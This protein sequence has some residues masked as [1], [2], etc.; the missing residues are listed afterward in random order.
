VENGVIMI[1]PDPRHGWA[2]AARQ[3]KIMGGDGD[4]LNE[5]D[6]EEWTW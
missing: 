3:M 6:H 4:F 1:K 2:E 5:F